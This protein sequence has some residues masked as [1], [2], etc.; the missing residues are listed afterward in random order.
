MLLNLKIYRCNKKKYVEFFFYTAIVRQK[1]PEP[2]YAQW[3][4]EIF[5]IASKF[6][7]YFLGMNL[8]ILFYSFQ[9]FNIFLNQVCKED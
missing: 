6:C 5:C 7:I 4:V 3:M 9:I 1:F 8:E 2:M